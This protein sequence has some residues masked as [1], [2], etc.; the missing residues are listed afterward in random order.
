MPIVVYNEINIMFRN[1]SFVVVPFLAVSLSI[2]F[3]QTV[4]AANYYIDA[5]SGS[6]GNDGT[7]TSTPWQTVTPVNSLTLAAGD[8]VFFKRGETF[9]NTKV[10]L[11]D[12]NGSSGNPIVFD[13]YG[14][15]ANPILAAGSQNRVFDL[16]NSAS[17]ITIQNLDLRNPSESGIFLFSGTFTGLNFNNL[18]ITGTTSQAILLSSNATSSSSTYDNL[19]ID[20]FTR[21]INFSSGRSSS[22]TFSNLSITSSTNGIALGSSVSPVTNLTLESSEI[23]G[24]SGD[25][26]LL[27]NVTVATVDSITASDCGMN[28]V[29]FLNAT[30]DVSIT[31]SNFSD[32]TE[33]GIRFSGRVVDGLIAT[34]TITGNSSDGILV[35]EGSAGTTFSNL[36][37]NS[38]GLAG[39]S[40]SL[41]DI[42]DTLSV[43]SSTF[44]GNGTASESNGME[45]S[46]LSGTVTISHSTA[47]NNTND[48]FNIHN[49]AIVNIDSSTSTNN[50][51]DGVGADGDGFSWHT[52]S[53]GSLTNSYA[54]DNKKSAITNIGTSSVSVYNSV[55]GHGSTAGTNALVTV[56]EEAA[57]SFYNNTLVNTE[58]VGTGI[59]LESIETVTVR[60]NIIYGFDTGISKSSGAINT[61]EDYNIVYNAGTAAVSGTGFVL[62]ANSL[63]SDPQL[64]D[65]AAGD[66]TLQAGSPAVNAGTDSLCSSVDKIGQSRSDGCDIGAYEG[67]ELASSNESGGSVV[68]GSVSLRSQVKSTPTTIGEIIEQ[69]KILRAEIARRLALQGGSVGLPY[70]FMFVTDLKFGTVSTD[71]QKLQQFLNEN[72]YIVNSEVDGAGHPGNETEYFGDLTRESLAQFQYRN[73][74]EPAV[75]FFGPITRELVNSMLE[76]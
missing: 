4:Q 30:N 68:G 64:T 33:R 5:T 55:F 8:Q 47:N 34:S 61:T 27:N 10:T 28:G 31:N 42:S 44:N 24:G 73:N 23:T 25:C 63:T 2:I 65:V 6:D 1:F 72:G 16:R 51:V 17:Y 19:I 62:G 22:D 35:L 48:G 37:V 71:V 76:I 12:D 7:S 11:F 59:S 69:L 54:W 20:G 36:T 29:H 13:A 49:E 56:I 26:V 15:G 38:N 66:Y 58:Q 21:G 18:S 46:G 50:G 60:N 39:L 32:N 75:G 41:D 45:V 40:V 57:M 53:Q 74:I 43:T 14:S 3:V 67:E 70:G 52:N 9:T